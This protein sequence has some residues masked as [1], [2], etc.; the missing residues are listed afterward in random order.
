MR[1]SPIDIVRLLWW[2]L[3]DIG[4]QVLSVLRFVDLL[5]EPA[6]DPGWEGPM[7]LTGSQGRSRAIA[8]QCALERVLSGN[9]L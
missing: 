7:Q 6:G 1:I 9:G 8:I 3:V 5:Q 4:S 2:D